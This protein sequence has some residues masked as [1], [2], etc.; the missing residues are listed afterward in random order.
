MG[1]AAI[2]PATI[3]TELLELPIDDFAARFRDWLADN[4]DA[5][6]PLLAPGSD[7]DLRVEAAREL[8]Q[9]LWGTGWARY[10][11]P[12][13]VGGAGGTSL[14]RAVVTEELFRAGW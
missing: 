14:H 11:W 3:S 4:Q 1:V 6:G 9:L 12:E 2:E 13:L 7:F 10:G 5:V 8:R